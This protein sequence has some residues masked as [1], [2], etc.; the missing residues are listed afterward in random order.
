VN[1]LPMEIF[2]RVRTGVKPDVNALSAVLIL[3]SGILA[4]T[5]ELIRYR[6]DQRR[7]NR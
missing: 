6:S 3:G 2:S 7:L 4:F 1:T 5:S